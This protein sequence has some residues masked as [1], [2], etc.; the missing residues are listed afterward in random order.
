[1]TINL[2]NKGTELSSNT[3]KLLNKCNLPIVNPKH[4]DA[5]APRIHVNASQ[6]VGK[7]GENSYT[8]AE[9]KAAPARAGSMAA[10]QIKSRGIG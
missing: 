1:M 7:R 9:L 10:Y 3:K 8:G 2:P 5:A 4:I 6:Y